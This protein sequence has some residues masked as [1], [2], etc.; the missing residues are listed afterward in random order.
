MEILQSLR[1]ETEDAVDLLP[2]VVLRTG[3]CIEFLWQKIMNYCQLH[4]V[5]ERFGSVIGMH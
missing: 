3:N 1:R 2:V 5:T 4:P